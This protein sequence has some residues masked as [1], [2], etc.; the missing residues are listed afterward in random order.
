MLIDYQLSQTSIILRVKIRN[1]SVSTG[2][3][4]TGL[5]SASSGLQIAATAD[6]ESSPTTYTV[7]GSTIETITTL[8]TFATPT[9]TKCRFKELS[10]TA[11][12]GIYEIQLDNARYAVSN[13]KSLL[14]SINGATNAAECDVVIP[15]RS[16]NPYDGV[17]SGMTALPNA[18]AAAN[19]GLPTVDGS[20][21]VKVSVG[22]GTGQI[23]VSS[24]KVPATMGS[25]DYTGN[26]VQTGDAYARI[27]A[28]G[29]GLSSL[30]QASTALS[31]ANWTNSLA[32]SLTTLAGHDPGATLASQTNITAGTITTVTNLTNL[33]SIPNNWLTAA[34]IAASALNGK[35]DWLLASS[36]PTNFAALG[37]S[38]SGHI[39]NVDTLTTYTGNT[40]QT[41]D[42]YARIGAAG[43]GLTA[44]G[45]TRIAHLDADITSRMATFTLPTHFSVLAIDASGFVT[46]N[47]S[48]VATTANQATIVADI[49]ALGSPMQAG[50]QVTVG[51]YGS[52]QDPATLVLDAMASG[53]NTAGTIGNKINTAANAGDPATAVLGA[54]ASSWNTPGTIGA[55]INAAGSAGDPW[56]TDLPGSYLPGSA[57]FIVG[58]FLPGCFQASSYQAE[59]LSPSL[60]NG[61]LPA[62]TPWTKTITQGDTRTNLADVLVKPTGEPI[63]L[64]GSAV[65][66]SMVS[67]TDNSVKVNQVAA[68][69]DDAPNGQVSYTWQSA[70]VN[71]AGL[72]WGWWEVTT[73]GKVE[74]FP[75]DGKKMTV[76]I[77]PR[78][79]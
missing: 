75:G 78:L 29:S 50:S 8:G 15:L 17:R 11:H 26:T 14:V 35:G 48:G 27:G 21:G 47:N 18:A 22:T 43:A 73:G 57:G 41:G 34:G 16:V 30:A 61:Q 25:T 70:D 28:T 46:F 20:N 60:I 5:T 53:H 45:D 63:N 54:T 36:A 51:G 52:G 3:G 1:S 19:G 10:S 12:P 39:S 9:A 68:N 64:T 33:P 69:L 32:T 65:T 76:N 37:I 59:P 24:G 13:C 2:A 31:N 42:A 58:T 7:A 72:Y 44:L 6:N 74:H 49:L 66:F 79:V 67:Q 4:L 23:N 71:T 77:V 40:P 55:K 38:V 62:N 56:G